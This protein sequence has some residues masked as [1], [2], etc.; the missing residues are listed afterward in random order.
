MGATMDPKWLKARDEKKL[1]RIDEVRAGKKV[2]TAYNG[3]VTVKA[4]EDRLPRGC[5]Y[6][7]PGDA[8]YAGCA[9]V[10]VL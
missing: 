8:L 9:E 10:L 5:I 6:T 7:D 1:T 3:I 4:S 2:L